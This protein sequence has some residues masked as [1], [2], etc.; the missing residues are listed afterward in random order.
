MESGLLEM[1]AEVAGAYGN[2]SH[3]SSPVDSNDDEEEDTARWRS[4]MIYLHAK[5]QQF[6]NRPFISCIISYFRER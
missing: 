6:L 2:V 5:N 3:V 4:G 1:E